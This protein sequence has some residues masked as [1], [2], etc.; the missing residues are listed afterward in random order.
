VILKTLFAAGAVAAL[1]VAARK[2]GAHPAVA[3]L[4]LALVTWAAEPRFVERPHLVTFLGL[5][6]LLVAVENAERG[7]RRMLWL[8][9][10]AALVWANANSCLFEAPAI[11]LLYAIGAFFDAR[12]DEEFGAAGGKAISRTAALVALGMA[13]FIL[14]TP[15]GVHALGYIA[16]HWHM[17]TLRPCRSTASPTCG[18]KTRPSSS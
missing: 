15:S 7:R 18:R 4:A 12:R 13:P 17:P 6:L 2:R 5:G 10:P 9:I 14:A 16:N 8:F 3:A 11:L 1:Y